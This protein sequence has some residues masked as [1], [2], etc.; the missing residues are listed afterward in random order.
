MR[1]TFPPR[2]INELTRIAVYDCNN[3]DIIVTTIYFMCILRKHHDNNYT[4]FTNSAR[5]IFVR[6]NIA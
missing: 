2:A 6:H 5:V 1:C 4:N 3:N